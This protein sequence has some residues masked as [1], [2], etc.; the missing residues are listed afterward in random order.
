[1]LNLMEAS[2]FYSR[3]VVKR[4][5]G[6]RVL[7]EGRVQGVLRKISQKK[8]YLHKIDFIL[9]D[10]YQTIEAEHEQLLGAILEKVRG[11]FLGLLTIFL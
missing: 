7:G 4:V 6:E 10:Y 11:I 9:A 8:V 3:E 1:M 2:D 5:Q